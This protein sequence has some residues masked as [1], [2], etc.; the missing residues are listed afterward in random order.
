M[1]Q[2]VGSAYIEI[3]AKLDKLEGR[4]TTEIQSIAQKS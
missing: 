3:E 2:K 4:L 1:E